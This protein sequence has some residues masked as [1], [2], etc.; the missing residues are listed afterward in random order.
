MLG[1]QIVVNM[2]MNV[3]SRK[4]A[5]F[6]V[7]LAKRWGLSCV[8]CGHQLENIACITKEH[9]V[10]HSM[11]GKKGVGNIAPSHYSCNQARNTMSLI[12]A[13]KLINQKLS[14][15]DKKDR[16]GWLTKKVPGRETPSWALLPVI[17]GAWFL[18]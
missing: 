14:A 17:D 7:K 12:E 11:G 8:V 13:N 18:V 15:M 2:F 10:P 1:V 5:L 16:H 4:S 6:Y 9:V 3:L